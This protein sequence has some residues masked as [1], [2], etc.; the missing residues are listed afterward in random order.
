METK[1]LRLGTVGSDVMAVMVH[2][3]DDVSGRRADLPMLRTHSA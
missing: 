3:V 2:A 1:A